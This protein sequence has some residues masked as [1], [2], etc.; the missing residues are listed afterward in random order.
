MLLGI[1]VLVFSLR[2]KKS[3]G[4]ACQGVAA[5]PLKGEDRHPYRISGSL[6]P[7]SPSAGW[8]KPSEPISLHGRPQGKSSLEEGYEKQLQCREISSQEHDLTQSC[9]GLAL[10]IT[11]WG[12]PENASSP[13][14]HH[15]RWP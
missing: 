1:F 11:A 2:V 13:G 5:F 8:P 10:P 7:P 15:A 6:R 4:N 9:W 14:V 3:E 12:Q